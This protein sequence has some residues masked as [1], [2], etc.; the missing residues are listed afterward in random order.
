MTG[1]QVLMRQ[2][3]Q[4]IQQV[5]F[6]SRCKPNCTRTVKQYET[7]VVRLFLSE[8]HLSFCEPTLVPDQIAPSHDRYRF[9][10]SLHDDLQML[11]GLPFLLRLLNLRRIRNHDHPFAKNTVIIHGVPLACQ[12]LLTGPKCPKSNGLLA[13]TTPLGRAHLSTTSMSGVIGYR[14]QI[15][16]NMKRWYALKPVPHSR[17]FPW[18]SW[19]CYRCDYKFTRLQP[20]GP[21]D[22]E[23]L[24]CPKC[25][26]QMR[27]NRPPLKLPEEECKQ[28]PRSAM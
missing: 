7:D 17:H 2:F 10:H 25:R 8:K 22:L 27:P 14:I 28:C 11:I 4:F 19:R 13:S 23:E 20:R 6:N 24:I 16:E 26:S 1:P 12:S 3:V 5:N 21:V 9:N 18:Y 15:Q